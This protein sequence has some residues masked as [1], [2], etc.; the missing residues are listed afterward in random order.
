MVGS[1]WQ[2]TRLRGW[3]ATETR[4]LAAVVVPVDQPLVDV[5]GV[6]GLQPAT[7]A[8]RSASIMPF[9]AAVLCVPPNMPVFI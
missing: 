5:R 4:V 6:V 7:S 1:D 2:G 9:W 8:L 3:R